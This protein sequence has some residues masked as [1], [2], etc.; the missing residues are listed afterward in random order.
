M[1]EGFKSEREEEV[2]IM[3]IDKI[4]QLDSSYGWIVRYL[5]ILIF[6]G[7]IFYADQR[8]PTRAEIEQ[9]EKRAQQIRKED[10]AEIN[11]RIMGITSNNATNLDKIS[12]I[13]ARLS[14]IEAQNEIIIR[15]LEKLQG[16]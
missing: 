5:V 6:A 4:K 8:Y 15:S 11:R 14:R 9:K 13:D 12:R 1:G 16:N 2:K 7:V 10:L 3:P